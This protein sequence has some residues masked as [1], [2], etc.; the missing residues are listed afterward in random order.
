MNTIQFPTSNNTKPVQ[1]NVFLAAQPDDQQMQMTYNYP[2]ASRLI[3][4]TDIHMTDLDEQLVKAVNRMLGIYYNTEEIHPALKVEVDAKIKLDT[5]QFVGKVK[6]ITALL[7]YQ[8]KPLSLSDCH[9]ESEVSVVMNFDVVGSRVDISNFTAVN[10]G[11]ILMRHRMPEANGLKFGSVCGGAFSMLES[12][13]NDDIQSVIT[14]EYT[15]AVD[16]LV[17]KH[18]ETIVNMIKTKLLA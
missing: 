16:F 18:Q 8:G 5:K 10:R 11:S 9:I 1:L 12:Y 17:Q 7:D 2:L 3:E 6:I 4:Q 15:R 13:S 14:G